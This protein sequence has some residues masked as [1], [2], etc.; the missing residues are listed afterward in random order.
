MGWETLSLILKV[1]AGLSAVIGI[2]LP[3]LEIAGWRL[4]D[5]PKAQLI[6]VGALLLGL[7]LVLAGTERLVDARKEEER[8]TRAQERLTAEIIAN[9]RALDS[10]LV[11]MYRAMA[12][13][14]WDS[15]VAAMRE[16]VAPALS[17]LGS[18]YT[19]LMAEQ[20]LSGLQAAWA[21]TPLHV[22][23]AANLVALLNELEIGSAAVVAYYSALNEVVAESDALLRALRQAIYRPAELKEE[24]RLRVDGVEVKTEMAHLQGLR[25][26][27]PIPADQQANLAASLGGLTQL[28]PRD[29]PLAAEIDARMQAAVD[30]LAHYVE[31]KGRLVSQEETKLQQELANYASLIQ[32]LE[33][34]PGDSW[35]EVIGK[36]I[37]VRQLGHTDQ[38]VRAFELYG[39][40]F[41]ETDPGAAPYAAAAMVF[42]RSL[43]EL[44]LGK[45]GRGGVYIYEIDPGGAARQAG[46]QAGDIII[47]ID[48]RRVGGMIEYEDA[49]Q[50]T[51]AQ[52]E[53]T[54]T[55]VRIIDG[56]AVKATARFRGPRL[57]ASIMP[58]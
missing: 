8:Q 4:V 57:Q 37:S 33:I 9:A 56:R 25:L 39:V 54:V 29:V 22:D 1:L 11:L 30:R 28:N 19:K 3:L 21:G 36:A 20:R 52:P 34:S 6:G 43:N 45:G 24:L 12:P 15:E 17:H 48:G 40:L 16:K 14:G 46:L 26:L 18:G 10:R 2:T 55:Y 47:A 44:A 7:A 50:A 13:S 41:S 32:E 53:R 31:E 35:S 49:I 38:A 51:A 5:L 58:I 42:T 27:L 23:R